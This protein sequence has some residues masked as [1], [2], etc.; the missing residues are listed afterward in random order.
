MSLGG[1]SDAALLPE[2]FHTRLSRLLECAGPRDDAFFIHL[3]DG[4]GALRVEDRSAIFR[5]VSL[6]PPCSHILADYIICK[7]V[8]INEVTKMTP[9]KSLPE[10]C[11]ES[12]TDT[13]RPGLF[14]AL[15]DPVRISIVAT[16]ATRSAPSTVSDIADCCGIDLSGVSRHLKILR[17]ANI[18]SATKDGRHVLYSLDTDMLSEALRSIADAL[19]VCRDQAA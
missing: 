19:D 4:A 17:D 14:K 18:L 16:L 2:W 7:L 12:L 9:P 11:T 15:C 13:M 3:F 10:C 5:E 1:D 6:Y 8:Q